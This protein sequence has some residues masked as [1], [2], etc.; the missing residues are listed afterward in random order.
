[1]TAKTF[2]RRGSRRSA[3]SQAF[4]LF[5]VYLRRIL[6]GRPHLSRFDRKLARVRL[7]LRLLLDGVK[8][9]ALF[10]VDGTGSVTSWNGGAQR[11][12]GYKDCDVIGK[13]F[14]LFF[15][16]ED[17]NAGIPG[18]LLAQACSGV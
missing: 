3:T 14:S 7:R 4:E 2:I 11:L 16:P 8:D 9:H 17:I 12:F 10:T 6:F 5:R 1:M 18:K 13:H 15:T